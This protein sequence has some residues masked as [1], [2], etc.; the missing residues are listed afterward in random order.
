NGTTR[1]TFAVD[2]AGRVTSQTLDPNGLKRVSDYTLGADDDLLAVT[3]KDAGGA[4]VGYSETI[5]D[6]AGPGTLSTT[7]PSTRLTPVGRGKLDEASGSNAADSAGNNPLPATSVTWTAD[8]TRGQVATFNGTS[9]K[10]VT[11]Y[12]VVDTTR[13]Y[14]F[15]AWVK[16]AAKDDSRY[17]A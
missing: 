17:I 4:V 13:D 5:Y 6:A 14:T 1:E 16:L 2:A 3:N 11:D 7:L 12:E 10:F 8:P 15:A 9:S